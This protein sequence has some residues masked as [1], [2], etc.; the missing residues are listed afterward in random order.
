[1][2]IHDYATSS[3]T[4]EHRSPGIDPT[5]S[6]C[7]RLSDFA[8]ASTRDARGATE[9]T[10]GSIDDD[11]VPQPIASLCRPENKC[12]IDTGF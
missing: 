2:K 7:V 4:Q 9:P 12:L 11:L 5:L 8:E 10:S 1:M 3:C 6:L